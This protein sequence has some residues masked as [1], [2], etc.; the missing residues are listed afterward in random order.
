M[1]ISVHLV[2]YMTLDFR[3]KKWKDLV[4]SNK[5]IVSFFLVGCEDDDK[6]H[7]LYVKEVYEEPFLVK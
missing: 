5:T 6:I 4:A 2:Y 3:N 1:D 7:T